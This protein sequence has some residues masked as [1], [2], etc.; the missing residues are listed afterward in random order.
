[1]KI[2]ARMKAAG[3]RRP[4]AAREYDIPFETGTLKELLRVIVAAEVERFNEKSEDTVIPFLTEKDVQEAAAAGKVS[5]GAVHSDRK[6]D[7]VKAYANA[8]ECFGDGLVRIFQNEKELTNP[9]EAV[10]LVEG[11]EF[12]FIRLT[13]LTG[14]LW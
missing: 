1:M 2:Y 13:F 9:E 11:D 10:T 5:F 8:L 14:R 12:L 4:V 7:P 6:A 3:K